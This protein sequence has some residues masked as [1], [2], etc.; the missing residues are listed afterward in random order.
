MLFGHLP[1][2]ATLAQ[3]FA[4]EL[5]KKGIYAV[6]FFYPVVPRGESRIRIQLSAAHTTLQVDTCVEVFEDVGK[7]LGV[8]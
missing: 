6:G 5:L 2:D 7:M 8:L 4:E 1:D 3:R